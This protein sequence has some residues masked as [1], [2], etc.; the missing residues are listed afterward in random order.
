MKVLIV[1]K[2]RQGNETAVWGIGADGSPVRLVPPDGADSRWGQ[3][4]AVNEV[5]EV[6]GTRPPE[7]NP[8][9]AQDLVV[10]E[11]QRVR[12]VKDVSPSIE[13]FMP[14]YA[15]PP[16]GLFSGLP[17]ALP[18]GSLYVSD[19]TG[20]PARGLAF[21]R[22]D[23]PLR[24]EVEGRRIVYRYS[25]MEGES[26]LPYVGFQ[27]AP[28]EIPAG[29][30]LGV[31][32]GQ[33][34]QP[35]DRSDEEPRC[36]LQLTGWFGL[37]IAPPA[38][39]PERAPQ[40]AA[41]GEPAPDLDAA[42]RVLSQVFGYDQFRPLQEEIISCALRGEDA[43]GIMPTG[44]GKSLCY[45]VPAL[46][47][48]G[49][50]V[51]V[52]PLLSLMQDQIDQLHE[53]G[54]SAVTLNS[55]LN[56]SAYMAAVQQ[57]RSG[58]A[59]LLYVA[60]ETLT[61]PDIRV[62]LEESRVSL[63]TVDEA[64]C[65]SEWGHD[66][67]PEYRRLREIR[68]ALPHA[69][70]LALT[71]TATPRVQGDIQSILNIPRQRTFIAGFNRPNL[72][73]EVRP[74]T[75]G[76]Q[77]VL[78][79][80]RAHPDQS[81]IVYASTRDQVDLLVAQLRENGV[82]AAPYHAGMDD[83]S[84]RENQRLFQRD[85]VPVVVATIAF[86]M[87]INKPNVR[88]IAHHSLPDCL[89]T[90]YQQIGRAGRDGL[91]SECVLLFSRG[92]A[93]TIHHFI[94]RGAPAEKPGRMARLQA[95]L[96]YAGATDCRRA[97][98]LGYF[99]DDIPEAPCGMC[100]NC[101]AEAEGRERVDVSA[102]ARLFLECVSQTGQRFGPVHL[103]E[104]LRGSKSARVV[105]WRH[106]GLPSHGAG[107]HRSDEAWRLLAERFIELG[108]V[109]AELQHGTLRLT[110][111]SQRVL[112]GEPVLVVLEEPKPT[113][114]SN[115]PTDYDSL[116]FERLRT[117]RKQLADAANV[118]PYVIFSDRSLIDMAIT[119]PQTREAFLRVHGV[120]ERR[121]E[122]YGEA[123]TEAIRAHV[124]EHGITEFQPAPAPPPPSA[125]TRGKRAQEV[126]TA[127][128][129]GATIPDLQE[130]WGVTV[131]TILGHLYTYVRTGGRLDP[132]R[133]LAECTLS[134][135][136]RDR[137]LATFRELGHAQLGPVYAELH[138]RV[139]YPDLHLLRVYRLCLE[140][141]TAPPDE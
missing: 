65:I 73:L 104:V 47:L 112:N 2:T 131:D 62:L 3:E 138:G 136:M 44:A 116:L 107:R 78:E 129:E 25:G 69:S 99:G 55:S 135:E 106:D 109:E 126:G 9:H 43:A 32:L 115:R 80:I 38:R 18:S 141:E 7:A 33:W 137:V 68:T 83:N 45:Q 96:R 39:A 14:P 5:W 29:T 54:V 97:P 120:G 21:W 46:L 42:R 4:F 100:D 59:K 117:L 118:P 114:A 51:V 92:D 13:R 91:R 58:E 93:G 122:S 74:R 111:A 20:L 77:Q 24:R 132:D 134:D 67:R 66:F 88:F 128:T 22:P 56:A 127:F 113:T 27:D 130:K 125:P 110:P 85:E 26:R 75:D 64:H 34:W 37:Q 121:A 76:V 1:A 94:E 89:E 81:G 23:A 17:Q 70:C 48:P 11:R 57:V 16:E 139:A 40:R 6:E 50:T 41:A 90:Y 30:L 95:M 87:G 103:V 105:K 71:A 31:S 79:L 86:G 133:L 101:R 35:A 72:F 28:E 119:Y 98:L 53:A 36:F 12:S 15:G 84:R 140:A 10:R 19:R 63:L 52:S 8:P 102:D 60:P 49:L 108:L 61:R 82:N 124:A 123:F